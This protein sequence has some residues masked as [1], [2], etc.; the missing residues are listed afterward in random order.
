MMHYRDTYRDNHGVEFLEKGGVS[1][2]KY[3]QS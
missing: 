1:V 2:T 3:E